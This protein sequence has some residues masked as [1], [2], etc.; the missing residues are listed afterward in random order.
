MHIK[1]DWVTNL[2]HNHGFLQKKGE[3]SFPPS[4]SLSGEIHI[5]SHQ[6]QF[7]LTFK[8]LFH[9]CQQITL[10]TILPDKM[11]EYIHWPFHC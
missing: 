5:K 1:I 8:S 9:Y 4:Y 10:K 3:G 6:S 7:L 2:G 11:H